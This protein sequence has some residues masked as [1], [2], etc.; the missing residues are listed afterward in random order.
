MEVVTGSKLK[1]VAERVVWLEPVR[2]K[3]ISYSALDYANP[4]FFV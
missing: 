4:F 1:V 3:I 2:W